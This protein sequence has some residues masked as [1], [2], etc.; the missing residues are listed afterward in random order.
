MRGLIKFI[1]S[2]TVGLAYGLLFAQK[3]GKKFRS[4]LAK[5]KNKGETLVK[6]LQKIDEE[7]RGSISEWA[8]NSEDLQR[9][10]ETG[11]EQFDVFVEKVKDLGDDVAEVAE[12]EL[13]TI[14]K[15]AKNAANELKKKAKAEGEKVVKK[16]VKKV[17]K[18][19][20]AKK[21]VKKPAKKPVKK[22]VKKVVK[23][24]AK[25]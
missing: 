7:A 1:L 20:P 10:M 18:K 22:T 14:A 2:A 16:V 23:K 8:K 11:K 12:Q 3:S 25:K 4:E 17:Q 19:T 6:E 9:V 5:S 13:E 24:V 21:T 15:N